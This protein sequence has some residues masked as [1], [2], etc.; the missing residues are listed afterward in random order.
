MGYGKNVVERAHFKARQSYYK[1]VFKEKL[2]YENTLVIPAECEKGNTSRFVPKNVRLVY[3]SCNTTKKYLCNKV[4]K[5]IKKDAGI[6]SIIPCN[7]CN[8]QYIGESDCLERRFQQHKSDLCMEIVPSSI[9]CHVNNINQRKLIESFLIKNIDNM[10]VY[11]VS[12]AI[13]DFIS[14]IMHNKVPFLRKFVK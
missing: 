7:S 14:S 10:N 12:I 9:L 3:N 13:D 1:S 4:T 8:L 11:R 2:K 5:G 6:Y